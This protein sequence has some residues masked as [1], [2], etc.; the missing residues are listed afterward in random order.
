MF[1]ENTRVVAF[2]AMPEVHLPNLEDDED[3]P[4]ER[5]AAPEPE[6]ATVTAVPADAGVSHRPS[7]LSAFRIILEVALIAMGV[8]LGL[9]GEQWRENAGQRDTAMASLRRLRSEVATNRDAVQRVKDY[10]ATTRTELR[11]YLQRDAKHHQADSVR[12]NGIQIV[13][14]EHTAWDLALTT[15]SLAHIDPDLAF[16]LS[17]IYNTQ[18]T[19]SELSRGI[20][21][22]MYLRPPAENLDGFLAALSV[23]YDDIVFFEPALLKM[24]GDILP[25]LDTAIDKEDV[26]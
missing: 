14:F 5:V 6:S 21:Q 3:V 19:V 9:A 15:Q 22:A 2:A 1:A 8:F 16:G 4:L 24:Y 13:P 18:Q 11:T 12:L 23:Y 7:G 10:H 26:R 17:R 25:R 20:T